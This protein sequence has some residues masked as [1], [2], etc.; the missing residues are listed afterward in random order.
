MAYFIVEMLHFQRVLTWLT[1][2]RLIVTGRTSLTSLL[3]SMKFYSQH[4]TNKN[5]NIKK[6]LLM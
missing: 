5:E 6:Y 3:F 1:I 2:V 4:N